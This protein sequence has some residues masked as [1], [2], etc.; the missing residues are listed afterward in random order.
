MRGPPKPVLTA[1]AQCCRCLKGGS[2]WW[3]I[4]DPLCALPFVHLS[5]AISESKRGGIAMQPAAIIHG[6][7]R[8]GN[9]GHAAIVNRPGIVINEGPNVRGPHDSEIAHFAKCCIRSIRDVTMDTIQPRPVNF[10]P[11]WSSLARVG[12]YATVERN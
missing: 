8:Y 9:D 4:V 12:P 10:D 6:I 5:P 2:G 11:W 1:W 3:A 7:R